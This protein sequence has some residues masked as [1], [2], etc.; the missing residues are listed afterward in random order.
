MMHQS[1]A[2][3]ALSVVVPCYNEEAVIRELYRRVSAVCRTLVGESYELVLV[4]D[5]SRDE[6]WAILQMPIAMT[7]WLRSIS[8]ATTATS[9]RYRLGCRSRAESAFW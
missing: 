2:S 5:G 3:S 8:H 4:N 1:Q 7:A 6:T 9:W